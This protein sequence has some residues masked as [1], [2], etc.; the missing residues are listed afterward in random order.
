[1]SSSTPRPIAATDAARNDGERAIDR[2]QSG[3]GG[4]GRVSLSDRFGLWLG[5]HRCSQDEF[6]DMVQGYVAHYGIKTDPESCAPRRSNGR[7]HAARARAVSPGNMCKTSRGGWVSR[8]RNPPPA[9]IRPWRSFH[10]ADQALRKIVPAFADML[11]PPVRYCVGSTGV[12][13]L[14]TSKCSCGL[15]TLPVA[16][17]L[18]M[19]C[20]ASPSRPSL[21]QARWH[22][23]RR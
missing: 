21:R 12:A 13:P 20:R 6:L 3:R 16:P 10:R 2:D 18:P 11:Q 1:M 14:R 23:R 8:L 22:A 17:A 4:R 5:F 9:L 15:V 19:T 7:R